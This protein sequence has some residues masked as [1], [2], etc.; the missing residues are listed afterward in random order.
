MAIGTI[1]SLISVSLGTK[2]LPLNLFGE[3]I[4]SINIINILVAL[5]VLGLS[6]LSIKNYYEDFGLSHE[7]GQLIPVV[8]N[9]F[10]V[11]SIFFIIN[12]WVNLVQPS[13]YL[14]FLFISLLLIKILDIYFRAS[15]QIKLSNVI[16]TVFY[17][18]FLIIGILLYSNI[19]K[20]IFELMFVIS[21]LL[22]L[23][24]CLLILKEWQKVK[25]KFSGTRFPTFHYFIENYKLGI[26][27]VFNSFLLL[28]D[29][30]VAAKFIG[31]EALAFYKV[32]LI[33]YLCG[34][35]PH[36]VINT[37]AGPKVSKIVKFKKYK[38][39]KKIWIKSHLVQFILTS[40]AVLSIYIILLITKDLIFP[41]HLHPSNL[42]FFLMFI[43]AVATAI[44]GFSTIIIIQMSGFRALFIGQVLYLL[45]FSF[46]CFVINYLF[47]SINIVLAFMLAQVIFT[48]YITLRTKRFLT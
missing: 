33:V 1:L 34:S 40:L 41:E 28:I 15:S 26:I 9:T 5:S 2:Y 12:S 39:L 18:L 38:Q 21:S 8:I 37:I 45:T 36:T 46:S 35:F 27:V 30:L 22:I 4:N 16:N 43:A 14:F 25:S 24:S 31:F 3:Y 6:E 23:T 42:N 44:R 13:I 48:F 7:L 20:N 32:C 29:Q 17:P 10:V 47:G 11:I 19:V